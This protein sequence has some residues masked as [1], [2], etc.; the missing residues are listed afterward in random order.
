MY[1][2]L[3]RDVMAALFD[4]RANF[5]LANKTLQKVEDDKGMVRVAVSL[6][7]LLLWKASHLRP[8]HPGNVSLANRSILSANVW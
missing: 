6:V 5:M 4:C 8:H 3:R 7:T 1:K 2:E